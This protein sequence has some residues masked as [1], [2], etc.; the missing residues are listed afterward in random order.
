MIA[1]EVVRNWQKFRMLSCRN[2]QIQVA[3]CRKCFEQCRRQESVICNLAFLRVSRRIKLMVCGLEI[4]CLELI[5]LY[6]LPES[7]EQKLSACDV[8]KPMIRFML[9]A[10]S[11]WKRYGK[12][13][14]IQLRWMLIKCVQTCIDTKFYTRTAW[15]FY[16]KT[17]TLILAICLELHFF[18]SLSFET[19]FVQVAMNLYTL[20]RSLSPFR[21]INYSKAM[22]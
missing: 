12:V 19:H 14:A 18:V 7:F 11:W 10:I 20:I 9:R 1:T 17:R 2:G 8:V 3:A 4:G 16:W 6:K 22:A 5:K 15:S 13:Y 21:S